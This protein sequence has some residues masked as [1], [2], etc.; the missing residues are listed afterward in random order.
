MAGDNNPRAVDSERILE[1]LRK[2]LAGPLALGV[3]IHSP[4]EQQATSGATPRV[5]ARPGDRVSRTGCQLGAGLAV[6]GSAEE[7]AGQWRAET[8]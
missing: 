8:L 3:E 7:S 1:R 4:P 2:G 5:I 6:P